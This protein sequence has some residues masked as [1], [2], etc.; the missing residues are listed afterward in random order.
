[1][2][3]GDWIEIYNPTDESINLSDWQ[4]KSENDLM[5]TFPSSS[6][7]QAQSYLVICENLAQ[8]QSVFPEIVNCIGDMELGLNN[9]S[10]AI[11][12]NNSDDVSIDMLTYVNTEPWPLYA[13][14]CT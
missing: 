11:S 1:M 6:I 8:F 14:G 13:N 10:M 2:A 3:A 4:L 12:L 9:N 7:I 5:Y